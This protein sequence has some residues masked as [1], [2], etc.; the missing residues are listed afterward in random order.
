MGRNF[1]GRLYPGGRTW[2]TV[3]HLLS[4]DFRLWHC[5][6]TDVIQMCSYRF[7]WTIIASCKGPH[8]DMRG[9]ETH[10]CVRGIDALH[11]LAGL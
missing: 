6:C 7:K 5:L 11:T 9:P 3:E 1:N 4:V 10:Q 8:M 2:L